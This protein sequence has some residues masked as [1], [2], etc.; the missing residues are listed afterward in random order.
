MAVDTYQARLKFRV[1]DL[2][3]GEDLISHMRTYPGLNHI[4]GPGV[5]NLSPGQTHVRLEIPNPLA[6]LA[7][8][9][10]ATGIDTRSVIVLATDTPGVLYNIST[11]APDREA[12]KPPFILTDLGGTIRT[13]NFNTNP[14]PV[15]ADPGNWL[16]QSP[17]SG[18][19]L[20]MRMKTVTKQRI[21]QGTLTGEIDGVTIPGPFGPGEARF[22][23]GRNN[24]VNLGSPN[25][26]MSF[27]FWAKRSNAL[28]T[29]MFIGLG[30]HPYTVETNELDLADTDGDEN[31]TN[32][33]TTMGVAGTF[34]PPQFHS[35]ATVMA[36]N[37]LWQFVQYE[38][39]DL[40]IAQLSGVDPDWSR[41]TWASF[42]G[43]FN[44][45]DD[46]FF[47]PLWV[48]SRGFGFRS[49]DTYAVETLHWNDP[50]SVTIRDR[51]S[52]ALTIHA[53]PT[54]SA[55]VQY[56]VGIQ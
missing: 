41:I 15:Y 38:K 54:Y 56:F 52:I 13:Q 26:G 33:L 5:I 40:T 8:S 19:N 2:R 37:N 42:N 30:S 45:G 36:G 27:G 11:A 25:D 12:L 49:L 32:Y 14:T 24:K 3:S 35:V 6:T 47:G 23:F 10:V 48:I 20:N 7:G 17:V 9:G 55:K 31:D 4:I 21:H 50:G 16:N 39:P 53:P 51:T 18:T 44:T 46:L 43:G 1:T 22:V 29:G 28:V 34:F